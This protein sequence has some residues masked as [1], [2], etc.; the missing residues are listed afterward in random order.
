MTRDWTPGTTDPALSALARTPRLLVA[1]DF[2]GTLS[3]HVADPMTARALP[4]AVAAVNRL[5]A[6]PDTFVAYA[7]GRSLHDLREVTEHDDSSR[8]LL[9]GSHGAQFWFPDTGEETDLSTEPADKAEVIDELRSLIADLDGVVYEPKTFGFG[10]HTRTAAPGQEELAF[11]RVEKWAPQ[12]IPT[13]RRRTGHHLREYSWRDE[14]KD[15]ALSRL[16]S[17]VQA[18]AVLFAGD[19]V[20]DEDGMRTLSGEDV[21]V[22]IGA[23][24]TAATL[25]VPDPA[26]FAVLLDALADARAAAQ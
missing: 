9:A 22:R 19:D 11:V 21:G 23:G 24:E 10:V 2:D 20:T 16:R 8:I 4:E 26:A 13:W 17:H 18:T 14:G 25:R 12:R 7:S 1:L 6:L 3:P 5:T 15:V